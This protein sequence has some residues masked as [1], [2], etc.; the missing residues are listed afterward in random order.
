[1]PTSDPFRP[2]FL[3][4]ATGTGK[5]ALAIALSQDFPIEIVNADAFQ[6]YRG[7]TTLTASPSEA[8]LAICP[9][10]LYGVLDPAESCDAGRYLT[11][12]RPVLE[13]IIQRSHIPVV[14]GGSGL[15]LKAL[16]HGLD[17]LLPVNPSIR[18]DLN[19]LTLDE[20]RERLGALD[21]VSL[22][23]IEPLN[24]RYLQRALE[25]S[26]T[27]NQPASQLRK[28]WTSDPPGL[29]GVLLERPREQLF[30][31]IEQRAIAMLDGGALEEVAAI[32][33]WSPTSLQAIG[34]REIQSHLRGEIDRDTCIQ[35]IQ[36]ITRRYAKRQITWFRREH[37]L[38]R[39]EIP[40]GED[41]KSQIAGKILL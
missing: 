41:W 25:I 17:D 37:W 27:A 21:P 7:L 26:L 33:S 38:Q 11:L 9:H 16:T 6:L 39:M 40:P 12:A 22:N 20:V 8:E 29:R 13:A 24:R 1:M 10:H 5:T 28:S 2:F 31:R 18:E 19:R 36:M 3:T 34:V 35:R 30:N 32:E 4:G 14:T 23:R 15:Y